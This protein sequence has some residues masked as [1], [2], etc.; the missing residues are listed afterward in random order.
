MLRV[1]HGTASGVNS[2]LFHFS[3]AVWGPWHTGVFLDANLPSLLA[4]GNLSAFA[5]RHDVVYRIFSTRHDLH[6]IK[7]TPVFQLARQIVRFE[8]IECAL[9][10]VDE[11]LIMHHRLWQRSINE[12]REAGAIVLFIP[13]DVVWSDGSF[14]HIAELVASGKRAILS[15][16]VR[17]VCETAV[18]AVKRAFGKKDAPII[19]V[20]PR[21]LVRVALEHIHPLSLT[22]MRDSPI[23]PIHPELVLWAVPGEGM[24]MRVLC[25]ELFAFDPRRF[26]LNQKAQLEDV[27]DSD[28]I[29]L[30]T[31]SDDLFA[32]SLARLEQDVDWYSKPRRLSELEIGRWWLTYD[33]PANDIIVRKPVYIHDGP[34]TPAKWRR[35]EIESGFLVNRLLGIRE[36]LRAIIW[37]PRQ[38]TRY[39]QL[40]VSMALLE[41]RLA[42]LLDVASPVTL[43][44][45]TDAAMT[46]W[47]LGNGA[48]A[49]L[50]E[51]GRALAELILGHIVVGHIDLI[52]GRDETLVTAGQSRRQL[53]WT[54]NRPL[55]DGVAV[56]S[57]GVA[58]RHHWAYLLDDVLPA[59]SPAR[60]VH[61]AIS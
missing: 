36:I 3:T 54:G 9:D 11:P 5:A 32:L 58:V 23:F 46:R 24:L 45:P 56:G 38:A 12:A 55:L 39:A 37:M 52:P 28:L 57:P 51:P 26:H 30:I 31:D 40:V 27:E 42:E 34:M 15:T 44:I 6:S 60:R 19:E 18:P 4:P 10:A 29:H 59:T 17:V 1:S 47:M 33:S 20:S 43:F 48:K 50:S 21:Q 13:P 22:Y 53:S 7:K 61:A 49:Y 8:L 2:L 41:T 14:A 35:V 25:R 16:F